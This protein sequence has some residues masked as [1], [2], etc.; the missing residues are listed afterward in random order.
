MHKCTFNQ[1]KIKLVQLSN[2]TEDLKQKQT[3]AE[4]WGVKDHCTGFDLIH[5]ISTINKSLSL[6]VGC[7]IFVIQSLSQQFLYTWPKNTGGNHL[8]NQDCPLIYG[9]WWSENSGDKCV[10][11]KMTFFALLF[12][13]IF[14]G[15]ISA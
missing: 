5:W 4:S 2:S 14:I 13:L 10:T 8:Q 15:I 11:L 3:Q 12:I 6:S 1:M 9:Q 7:R